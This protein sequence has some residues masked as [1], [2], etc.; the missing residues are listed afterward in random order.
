MV[1]TSVTCSYERRFRTCGKLDQVQTLHGCICYCIW[2]SAG[3]TLCARQFPWDLWDTKWHL[4]RFSVKYFNFRLS[5]SFHV[6]Q[7]SLRFPEILILEVTRLY[8]QKRCDDDQIQRLLQKTKYVMWGRTIIV[9]IINCP[10]T[11]WTRLQVTKGP[12]ACRLQRYV[13]AVFSNKKGK[14]VPLQA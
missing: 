4:D 7:I 6:P 9:F 11:V 3:Y 12:V 1:P 5:V 13:R 14:V 2:V 8:G 10:R